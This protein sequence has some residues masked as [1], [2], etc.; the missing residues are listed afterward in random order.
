[1]SHSQT[2][3]TSQARVETP[4]GVVTISVSDGGTD[5]P[6]ALVVTHNVT[7]A[8]PTVPESMVVDHTWLVGVEIRVV[9]VSARPLLR[10]SLDSELAGDPEPGEHLDSVVFDAGGRVMSLGVRD[11]DWML[12]AG[13]RRGLI[14]T[15]FIA[16]DPWIGTA[17]T[18]EHEDSGLRIAYG[19][20][21]S[22]EKLLCPLA[23]AVA[24]PPTN[25]ADR[26]L[27]TWFGV[28]AVLP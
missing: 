11:Q 28:D 7:P 20:L 13:A 23:V 2:Q 10:F 21:H 25:A 4:L 12:S 5:K 16:A 18:V 3:S 9:G 26:H 6:D 14:P 17:Y 22:G 8:R 15:R 1:M 19:A 27:W 24:S